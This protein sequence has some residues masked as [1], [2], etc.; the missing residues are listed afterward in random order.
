MTK[1]LSKVSHH[2]TK[3]GGYEHCGSGD[4]MVLVFHMIFQD[5]VI[6]E[7]CEFIARISLR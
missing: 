6:K 3:F 2:P 7:S 5:N 4:I 1:G